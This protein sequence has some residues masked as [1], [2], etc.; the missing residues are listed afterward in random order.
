MLDLLSQIQIQQ[1]SIVPHESVTFQ[2]IIENC[3]NWPRGT[4]LSSLFQHQE[5]GCVDAK[6]PIPIERPTSCSPGFIC[7][8]PNACDLSILA[9]PASDR[10]R[11]EMVFSDR[12]TSR[13]FAETLVKKLCAK[14]A[15]LPRGSN[16]DAG[17]PSALR[18]NI[19]QTPLP[20]PGH[21]QA[22]GEQNGVVNGISGGHVS[23]G[24]VNGADGVDHS[25]DAKS[26]LLAS[27]NVN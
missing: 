20:G 11:I 9:I 23:D 10:L 24:T 14:V 21:A 19:P 16:L 12:A 15:G 18:S 8:A 6:Q 25:M 5:C 7:P 3:S 1:A 22:N 27:V 17:L 4:R 26:R 2:R 13:S